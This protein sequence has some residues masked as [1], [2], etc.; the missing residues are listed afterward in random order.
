MKHKENAIKDGK[1]TVNGKPIEKSYILKD[2]DLVMHE[3]LRH[4]RR[5]FN[6]PIDIIH[7]DSKYLVVNK[8]ASIPCHPG[9]PFKFNSL[10]SILE[11]EMGYKNLFC[12]FCEL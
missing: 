5:V 11:H 8:P 2:S 6:R 4:E 12:I 7:D 10:L 1:I 3:L 9:G